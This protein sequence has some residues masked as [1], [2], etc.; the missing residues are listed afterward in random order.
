VVR[1]RRG[2]RPTS[3]GRVG[4]VIKG[5]GVDLVHVPRFA[6]VLARTPRMRDRLFTSAEQC[7]PDGRALDATSLAARFAAKEAIAKA[8]GAPPG[9]EW[10][11]CQVLAAAGGRPHVQ[12][13]D[14]VADAARA[15]G[16]ESWHVS[17]SH[18]GD[19][20]IAYVIAEGSS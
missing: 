15:A 16:I 12:L 13:S 4:A 3:R 19:T 9:L 8:L 1:C 18:D 11:H 6:A 2:R 14:S 20:A 7:R 5:I 10:H 17:L